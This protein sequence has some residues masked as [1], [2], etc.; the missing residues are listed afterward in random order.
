MRDG[1]SLLDDY[2]GHKSLGAVFASPSNYRSHGT[3]CVQKARLCRTDDFKIGRNG[4]ET[5]RHETVA[6]NGR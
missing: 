2:L 3:N 1:A 6:E 4:L 5:V